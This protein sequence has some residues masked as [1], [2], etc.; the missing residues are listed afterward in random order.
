MSERVDVL[1]VLRR[2]EDLAFASGADEGP[3]GNEPAY[4]LYQNAQRARA[5][6]AEL[7]E[8]DREY[9]KA[10]AALDRIGVQTHEMWARLESAT[11]RRA[12]ALSRVGA[13]P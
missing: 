9:D 5:A 8:A 2:L 13:A 12:T 3:E 10:S 11:D 7:I 1:A 6:V 4:R